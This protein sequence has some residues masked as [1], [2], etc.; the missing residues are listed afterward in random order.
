MR[1]IGQGGRN[2]ILP[3]SAAV[4]RCGADS[5]SVNIDGHQAARGGCPREGRLVISGHPVTGAG[6]G[7][8]GCGQRNTSR[9]RRGGG[10]HRKDPGRGRGTDVTGGICRGGT[11][12]MRTIGQG[13]RNVVLPDPAAVRG[14][15]A[16]RRSVDIDRHQAARG[17]RPR[18]GR[19][20]I[21]GHPVTGTGTGIGGC[22]QRNTSRDCRG[23]GVHREDPGG[24]RGT[25]VT[26][27]IRRGGTDRMRA[28]DQG[29]RNVIL[30]DSAAVRRCG[31]DSRSVNIDGHQ[32]ARG[33]CPREGRLVISG[34]PVTGAGAGIGGCGQRNP[35]RDR[36]G[37]GV[38]RK[39]PGG[40]RGTD[41]TGGIR[42][43]GTHRMR[44]IGQGCR[45]VILPDPAAVRGGGTDSRA[46]DID[47]H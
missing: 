5:R 1:A 13:G 41:V 26:G 9:D 28:V 21:T 43:G 6:S 29:S 35:C 38:H 3:D 2:I 17:G 8:G 44:A 12:R 7:I 31:A 10:V 4:R 40:C 20:G 22:G 33:G 47:R 45:D 32:A 25:D 15:G 23:G 37:G 24:C 46:I 39:A 36:R 16:D 18:Q 27:G 30:P 19:L 11:D 42:R 34:H 14:G